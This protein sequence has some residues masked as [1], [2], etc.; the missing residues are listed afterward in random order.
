[1]KKCHFLIFLSLMLPLSALAMPK[2]FVNP[3]DF[4][5]TE[6]E[7]KAVIQYVKDRVKSDL[8]QISMDQESMLRMMEEEDLKAFKLLTKVEDKKMLSTVID[9]YCNQ[10]N[11]CSYQILKMMYEEESQASHKSLS[12]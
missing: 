4:T 12:W 3:N 8:K 7:E 11:M 9:T 5:D 1:M 10:I 6:E 2:G